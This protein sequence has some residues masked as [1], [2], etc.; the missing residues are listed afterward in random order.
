[1]HRRT[2]GPRREVGFREE[3][4]GANVWF[5]VPNDAGAFDGVETKDGI[6]CVHPVQAYV[7]L[8]GHPERAKEPPQGF[9]LG[10]SGGGG[11]EGEEAADREWLRQS[12]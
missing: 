12:G 7:D 10:C 8:L 4:K 6:A 9:V 11:P 1:M 3:P 2:Q 5:V